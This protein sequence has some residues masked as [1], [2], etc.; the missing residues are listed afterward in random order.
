MR[1]VSDKAA[2]TDPL[3]ADFKRHVLYKE[4]DSKTALG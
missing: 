4:M 2:T 1:Q 3:A